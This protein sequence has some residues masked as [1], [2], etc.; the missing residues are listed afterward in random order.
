ME[1][2]KQRTT[3]PPTPG[4]SFLMT[5]EL[6]SGSYSFLCNSLQPAFPCLRIFEI[7]TKIIVHLIDCLVY[8]RSCVMISIS[9]SAPWGR[10]AY[11]PQI[12]DEKTEPQR[13][14]EPFLREQSWIWNPGLVFSVTAMHPYMT[15]GDKNNKR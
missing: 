11:H 7:A 4:A 9:T 2:Q 3:P 10:L 8:A 12:T 5:P 14:G 13:A 15:S 6:L 1:Q